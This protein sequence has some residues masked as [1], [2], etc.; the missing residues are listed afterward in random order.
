MW[1]HGQP[2]IHPALSMFL[3]ALEGKVNLCAQFYVDSSG[4]PCSV[5]NWVRYKRLRSG[6]NVSYPTRTH[7]NEVSNG[8]T[9]TRS[10]YPQ[11]SALRGSV[12]GHKIVK[13][14]LCW[15]RGKYTGWEGVHHWIFVLCRSRLIIWHLFREDTRWVINFAAGS[16]TFSLSLD[17]TDGE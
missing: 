9:P 6:C 1:W 14:P 2:S 12:C 11:I 10:I 8:V 3:H 13:E 15:F 5:R 7:S 17:Y 4:A 16:L